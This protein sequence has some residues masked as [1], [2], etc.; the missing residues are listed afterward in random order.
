MFL[1]FRRVA[2]SSFRSK[3]F[4]RLLSNNN[5]RFRNDGFYSQSSIIY[6]TYPQYQSYNICYFSKL[7]V[8]NLTIYRCSI[9]F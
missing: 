2:I 8:R 4:I 1:I 6:F 9:F 5:R 7:T 3:N